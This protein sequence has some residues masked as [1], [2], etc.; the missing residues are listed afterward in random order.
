MWVRGH[1]STAQLNVCDRQAI[2][3]ICSTAL[4]SVDKRLGTRGGKEE[5]IFAITLIMLLAVCAWACM[6]VRVYLGPTAPSE[7]WLPASLGV[8]TD[9]AV[10]DIWAGAACRVRERETER[11]TGSLTTNGG[12]QPQQKTVIFS[13]GNQCCCFIVF[14]LKKLEDE[15]NKT[16]NWI[17]KIINTKNFLF[18]LINLKNNKSK[19]TDALSTGFISCFFLFL[20]IMKKM[21]NITDIHGEN[22]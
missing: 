12:L 2:V 7:S 6:H 1:Y 8:P 20:H 11:E 21:H 9:L 16:K 14:F 5:S 22:T 17:W 18:C 19:T 4:S 15:D 13:E 3:T 10:G